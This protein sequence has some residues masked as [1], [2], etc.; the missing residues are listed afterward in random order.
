MPAYSLVLRAATLEGCTLA[1][2]DAPAFPLRIKFACA[3]CREAFPKFAVL[4]LADEKAE[5]PGGRG[6]ATFVAR[7]G[8][9]KGAGSADVVSVSGAALAAAAPGGSLRL[10]ELECRG[11]E[12]VG[13]QAGDGF[14]VASAAGAAAWEG[15]SFLEEEAFCE[16]DEAAEASV[17]VSGV[18]GEFEKK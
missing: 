12:P 7:C 1:A 16:Y 18:T 8:A 6:A 3:A 13:F 4:S 14:R 11:L 2:A 5:V 9:C 17:E 15:V 10:A